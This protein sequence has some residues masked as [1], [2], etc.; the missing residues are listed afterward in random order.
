[1]PACVRFRGWLAWLALLCLVSPPLWA[2]CCSASVKNAEL[3]RHGQS[4]LLNA[5]VNYQL[6]T[7]ALE[8]LQNGVPLFWEIELQIRQPRAFL[9]AKTVAQAQIR[10]RL[11]YHALLNLYRV[12]NESAGVVANVSSLAAAFDLMANVTN[13]H[14]TDNADFAPTPDTVAAIKIVFDRNAL[15]LPLRPVAYLN[16]QWYLSSDWSLWPLKN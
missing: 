5:E 6:S 7:K 10:Y 2:D 8:A 13:F 12:D 4:Y 16:Q 14:L 1:M 3:I 15:P 11:Q 9:W